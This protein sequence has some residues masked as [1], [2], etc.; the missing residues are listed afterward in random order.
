MIRKSNQHGKREVKL[1]SLIEGEKYPEHMYNKFEK[2]IRQLTILEGWCKNSTKNKRALILCLEIHPH[3]LE[4]EIKAWSMLYTLE[5]KVLL[6]G[7]FQFLIL[8]RELTFLQ[9]LWW[10]VLLIT[11]SLF[12]HI[13]LYNLHQFKIIHLQISFHQMCLHNS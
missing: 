11:C 5:G 1:M 2:G 4:Q 12:N 8:R 6:S 13:H 3:L 10:E 9:Y 7:P